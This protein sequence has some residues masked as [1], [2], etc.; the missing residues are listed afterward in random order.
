MELNV[1]HYGTGVP[2]ILFLHGLSSAGPVWW[3]VAGALEG[4]GYPSV[5]PDLRGH[6]HSAHADEY[7]LDLYARD[8]LESCPGPWS[9]VVG[10][11]LGGAVAVRAASM[12]RHFATAYLLIDPGIT[13]DRTAAETVHASIVA[14]VTD[15]PGVEQ[16][17]GEHPH[18]SREDAERKRESL[19]AT[20]EKV[21]RRTFDHNQDWSLDVRLQAI[22]A[23]VHILGADEEPLYTEDDFARHRVGAPTLTFERVPNTGHSIYRDDP[24]TVIDRALRLLGRGQ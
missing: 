21:I 14:D 3:R 1:R 23:P 11:S 24:E 13:I 15:P 2:S 7:V 19:C 9:L 4:A 22:A 16:L 5:A 6:G 17:L 12:D 10:H 18:W 20:S 8:V